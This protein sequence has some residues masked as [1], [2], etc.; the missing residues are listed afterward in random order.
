MAVC[1]LDMGVFNPKVATVYP[2]PPN[3]SFLIYLQ[4]SREDYATPAAAI[5]HLTIK[6]WTPLKNS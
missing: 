3:D 5:G 2:T 4:T 1:N 6:F